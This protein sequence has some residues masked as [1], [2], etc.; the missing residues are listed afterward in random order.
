M[1]EGSDV[2]YHYS[3]IGGRL[4]VAAVEYKLVSD[5]VLFEYTNWYQPNSTLSITLS[6][7]NETSVTNSLSWSINLSGDMTRLALLAHR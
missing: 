3:D 2:I 7:I 5:V 1:R 6:E 4:L